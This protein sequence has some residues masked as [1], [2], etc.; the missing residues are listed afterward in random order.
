M[1]SNQKKKAIVFMGLF[2]LITALFAASLS[3][4]ELQPGLPPVLLEGY[5]I[6]VPEYAQSD[7]INL[8]ISPFTLRLLGI[9]FTLFLLIM[10]YT[11]IMG[12]RLKKL[13]GILVEFILII[14]RFMI[15]IL[16][17]FL[18]HSLSGQPAAHTSGMIPSKPVFAIP[19]E[20]VPT[21]L[22]WLV[23]ITLGL[24]GALLLFYWTR[25][26]RRSSQWDLLT[27]QIEKARQNILAGM[28]LDKVIVRCYL[29]MGRILQYERGIER[30]VFTT[31]T[32]FE[33]ELCS[34]G[35]PRTPVHVLTNLFERVRYG[36]CTPTPADEQEAL[37]NLQK[38]IIHLQ[39]KKMGCNDG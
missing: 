36:R 20:A 35:L 24:L 22:I 12:I 31:P 33:Y 19:A 30:Q 32:E 21:G 29:E 25:T 13:F 3:Q 4:M 14:S 9:L 28:N 38:I 11:A 39:E 8:S 27:E 37:N 23:G 26:H 10:L 18:L 6:V 34:A 16:S 7:L 17:I 2:V 15:L 5:H 1:T